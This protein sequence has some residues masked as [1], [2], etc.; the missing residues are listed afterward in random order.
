MNTLNLFVINIFQDFRTMC[1]IKKLLFQFSTIIHLYVVSDKSLTQ[2]CKSLADE[3]RNP[4]I[5]VKDD[6]HTA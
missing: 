2:L 1:Y 3:E 6:S 5:V 4:N